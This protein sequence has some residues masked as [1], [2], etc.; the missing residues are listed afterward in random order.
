MKRCIQHAISMFVFAHKRR[1]FTRMIN[2]CI[3]QFQITINDNADN[4]KR[5]R[6][7]IQFAELQ[8]VNEIECL[9]KVATGF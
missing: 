9:N 5:L 3:V 1:K 6:L 8:T 4:S 2:I 7:L